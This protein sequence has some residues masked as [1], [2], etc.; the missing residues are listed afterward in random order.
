MG[1]SAAI[2]A[3]GVGT[4]TEVGTTA[5]S[6]LAIKGWHL[7]VRLG[8]WQTGLEDHSYDAM[9]DVDIGSIGGPGS[10]P[11]R[12]PVVR[13]HL[14]GFEPMTAGGPRALK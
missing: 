10:A 1:P 8:I 5:R 12:I 4:K 14:K 3:E 13:A 2:A 6:P 11:R 7:D 9:I